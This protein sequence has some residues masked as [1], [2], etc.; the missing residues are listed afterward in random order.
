MT[1]GRG[2]IALGITAGAVAVAT[3]AAAIEATPPALPRAAIAASLWRPPM[4]CVAVRAGAYPL[5]AGFCLTADRGLDW[6]A[7]AATSPTKRER[8]STVDYA[9]PTIVWLTPPTAASTDPACPATPRSADD[10][11]PGSGRMPRC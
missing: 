2:L 11:V 9:A 10:F 5:G 4:P 6:P 7:I 1:L 3:P 8:Q